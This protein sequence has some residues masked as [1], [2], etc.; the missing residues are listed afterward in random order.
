MPDIVD[1]EQAKIHPLDAQHLAQTKY[2]QGKVESGTI[3]RGPA[4][5]VYR[6]VIQQPGVSGTEEVVLS[7]VDGGILS[8]IHRDPK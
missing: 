8:T 4:G 2:P 3:E 6:F 5:L 7:A 1:L